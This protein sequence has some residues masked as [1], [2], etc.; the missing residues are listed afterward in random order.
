MRPLATST[1]A[2]WCWHA[3]G[4]VWR[5]VPWSVAVVGPHSR[6]EDMSRGVDEWCEVDIPAGGSLAAAIHTPQHCHAGRHRGATTPRHDCHGVYSRY[7]THTCA[8]DFLLVTCSEVYLHTPQHC[9]A[10]G[11]RGA[12]TPRHGDHF[13]YIFSHRWHMQFLLSKT[14]L[15]R[16]FAITTNC[17]KRS[18]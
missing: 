14:F 18:A 17:I 6:R 8:C 15:T 13:R 10:R 3:L 5:G 9:H 7:Y 16:R 12:T 11:H 2:T 4:S 1:L